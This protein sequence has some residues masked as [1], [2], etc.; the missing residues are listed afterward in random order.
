MAGI[1]LLDRC[2]SGVGGEKVI[3]LEF[4]Q[5]GSGLDHSTLSGSTPPQTPSRP[6]THQHFTQP[7]TLLRSP[8]LPHL[9]LS[10]SPPT[11]VIAHRQLPLHLRQ[12][13]KS[14][15]RKAKAQDSLQLAR[16]TSPQKFPTPTG[17]LRSAVAGAVPLGLPHR[18]TGCKQA[19]ILPAPLSPRPATRPATRLLRARV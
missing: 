19:L 2:E 10:P 13:V 1:A 12:F 17:S 18:L 3:D 8:T 14:R 7:T 15:H 11:Q 16:L 5:S 4:L 6:T 9:H